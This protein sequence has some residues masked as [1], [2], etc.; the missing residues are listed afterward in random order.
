MRWEDERYV[1]VY[2]RDTP[3]WL[4]LSFEAQALFLMLLRK[5]DR[6]G[7]LPLGKQGRRG[8]AVSIGHPGKWKRLE[9]ALDELLTD[10][11]I[12]I[13]GDTLIAPNFIEAQET[14]QSDAQRQRESRA[15]AR[16]LAGKGPMSQNVTECHTPSR[17]VTSGHAASQDVTPSLAVPNLPNRAEPSPPTPQEADGLGGGVG[18]VYELRQRV[19]DGLAYAAMG[20]KV[21]PIAK[22]DRVD[23]VTA[24]LEQ[25]IARLGMDECVAVCREAGM[26][27]R[28]R[29]KYMAYFVESLREAGRASGRVLPGE[30]GYGDTEEAIAADAKINAERLAAYRAGAGGV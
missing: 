30:H 2:T 8:V 20:R 27:S 12:R 17:G 23:E 6:A 21:W 22:P 10:G 15:R 7:I 26:R 16:E 29:V 1:R 9:P 25:E 3:D 14:P 24:A 19:F 5:V 11:C 4:A 13:E 18:P 28:E